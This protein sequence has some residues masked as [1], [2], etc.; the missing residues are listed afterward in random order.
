MAA[1]NVFG[2]SSPGFGGIASGLGDGHG[3]RTPPP[4]K[5][6]MNDP[7]R[8]SPKPPESFMG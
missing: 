4:P 5:I 2:E 8:Q 3:K 6:A 7:P 1:L